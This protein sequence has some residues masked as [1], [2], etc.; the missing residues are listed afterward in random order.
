MRTSR[1]SNHCMFDVSIRPTQ[2]PDNTKVPKLDVPM[3][4]RHPWL[5]VRHDPTKARADW[6]ET[7]AIVEIVVFCGFVVYAVFLFLGW[8]E[9]NCTYF[10]HTHTQTYTKSY[11]QNLCLDS[12]LHRTAY[13]LPTKQHSSAHSLSRSSGSNP[14]LGLL[15]QYNIAT[16]V[17]VPL[18]RLALWE[19]C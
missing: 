8:E 13:L 4:K 1:D 11:Q 3:L 18:R 6:N 7:S 5:M 12:L 14:I 17:A 15:Q 9:S 2:P 10:P 19:Q 16:L